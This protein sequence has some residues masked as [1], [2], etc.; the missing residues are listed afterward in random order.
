MEQYKSIGNKFYEDPEF[1]KAMRAQW[2]DGFLSAVTDA[3]E[4]GYITEKQAEDLLT[5]TTMYEE[6]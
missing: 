5:E 4:F 2:N 3:Q 6:D 1:R